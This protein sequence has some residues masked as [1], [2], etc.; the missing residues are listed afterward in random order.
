MAF[1]NSQSPTVSYGS[2]AITMDDPLK[3]GKSGKQT[4]SVSTGSLKGTLKIVSPFYQA[5]AATEKEDPDEV[6][7]A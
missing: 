5:S 7:D 6:T 3:N 4:S 1:R 2:G